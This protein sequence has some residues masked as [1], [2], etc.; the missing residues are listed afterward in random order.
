[1]ARAYSPAAAVCARDLKARMLH[2]APAE[3]RR[4]HF[5]ACS[6]NSV[7]GDCTRRRHCLAPGTCSASTL[8]ATA[9]C[10]PLGREC[11][12]ARTHNLFLNASTVEWSAHALPAK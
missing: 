9:A 1:M 6:H 7:A 12:S 11:N 3:A 8:T 10:Q 2:S 5:S 4:P